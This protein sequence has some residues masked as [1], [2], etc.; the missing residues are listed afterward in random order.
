MDLEIDIRFSEELSN[1]IQDL[2]VPL[3]KFGKEWRDRL[4]VEQFR[5]QTDAAGGAWKELSPAYVRWKAVNGF[6]T[7]IG[8]LSEDT[9][10]SRRYTP[11]NQNIKL[12]YGENATLFDPRRP[13]FTRGLECPE[14]Y[15]TELSKQI[16]TYLNQ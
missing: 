6:P 4:S 15:K 8:K 3:E 1:K 12:Q 13:L 7:T 16:A 14:A 10:N 5:L 2:S 11:G 9:F